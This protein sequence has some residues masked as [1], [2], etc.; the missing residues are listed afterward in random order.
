VDWLRDYGA[1]WRSR[2]DRLEKVLEEME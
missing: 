1:F 2:F